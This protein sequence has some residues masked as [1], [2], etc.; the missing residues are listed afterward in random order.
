MQNRTGA[1]VP[2]GRGEFELREVQDVDRVEPDAGATEL[3]TARATG[4]QVDMEGQPQRRW[5]LESGEEM[6]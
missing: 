3:S 4:H 6:G 2:D 1:V 5:T